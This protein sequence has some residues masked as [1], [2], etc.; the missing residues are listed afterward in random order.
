MAARTGMRRTVSTGMRGVQ[1]T[2]SDVLSSVH[3]ADASAGNSAS[4]DALS[5]VAREASKT[6]ASHSTSRPPCV[7]VILPSQVFSPIF[8]PPGPAGCIQPNSTVCAG[9]WIQYPRAAF[10][11]HPR[12]FCRCAWT[13]S[14]ACFVPDSMLCAD[15]ERRH[16]DSTQPS[17][18]RQRVLTFACARAISPFAP[19]PAMLRRHDR[20]TRSRTRPR[21]VKPPLLDLL[22]EREAHLSTTHASPYTAKTRCAE[23]VDL[24]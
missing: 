5:L 19:Q 15:S 10:S 14:P 12:P 1:G 7:G 18:C 20:S 6:G 21:L 3:A 23:P 16:A 9:P 13:A 17:P 22:L 4:H 24:S 2:I 8:V 11:R